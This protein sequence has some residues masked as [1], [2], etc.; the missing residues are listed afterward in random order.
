M[1]K[2]INLFVQC[3]NS[4]LKSVGA[5]VGSFFFWVIESKQICSLR[6]R[7]YLPLPSQFLRPC[8]KPL[9]FHRCLLLLRSFSSLYACGSRIDLF[10]LFLRSNSTGD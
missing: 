5:L 2:K 1:V 8:S 9:F 6:I 10:S 3:D 7:R 4:G